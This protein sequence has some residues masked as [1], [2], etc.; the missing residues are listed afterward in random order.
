MVWSALKAR[1]RVRP[2]RRIDLAPGAS[3]LSRAVLACSGQCPGSVLVGQPERQEAAQVEPGGAVMQPGVVLV[4]A[5]VGH[6]SVAAGEP[7]D[8]AFDYRPVLAVHAL[9]GRGRGAHP[10]FALELVMLTEADFAAG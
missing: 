3:G 4:H 6:P 2:A 8:G 5:P 10:V 7:R 1:Q 9:E